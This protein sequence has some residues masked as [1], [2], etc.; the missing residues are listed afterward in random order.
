MEKKN[1]KRIVLMIALLSYF[2]T[3][4]SNSIVITG[5]TKISADLH[6]SQISLS[7]VQNA[8]GLAFGSFILLSGKLGDSFGRR[9][10]LN[11]ALTIFMIGS[12]L[13]GLAHSTMVS[14]HT[15]LN[16]VAY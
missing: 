4:L 5:L 3:A 13:T 7:W 8:F 1:E 6:L 2:L 9:R 14:K 12:L 15:I 16:R 10:V 11:A